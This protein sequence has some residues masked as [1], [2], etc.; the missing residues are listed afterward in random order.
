MNYQA[1]CL[2]L[3][4]RKSSVNVLKAKA[5]VTTK[6]AAAVAVVEVSAVAATLLV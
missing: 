4:A 3:G 2:H 5:T 6:T 1:I